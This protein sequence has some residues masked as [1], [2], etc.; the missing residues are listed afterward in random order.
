MWSVQHILAASGDNDL[1]KVV[2]GGIFA[3]IWVIG[4]IA[5]AAAK[6]RK[7]ERQREI[8]MEL[9]SAARTAPRWDEIATQNAPVPPMPPPP[10]QG[11]APQ[12]PTPPRPPIPPRAPSPS[13]PKQQVPPKKKKQPRRPPPVPAVAELVNAVQTHAARTEAFRPAAEARVPEPQR[14][15]GPSVDATAL[16]AWLR[17]ATLRQQ[18]ILTEILQPPLSQRPRRDPGYDNSPIG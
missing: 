15:T 11:Q 16:R 5:S 7:A 6:R 1:V 4:A 10:N 2:L 18:F 8:Q 13:R 17:P 14:A 9:E 12:A 3:L